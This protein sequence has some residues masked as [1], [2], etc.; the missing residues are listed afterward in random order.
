MSI[1]ILRLKAWCHNVEQNSDLV[2]YEDALM[3]CDIRKLIAVAEA[4]KVY[5][6]SRKVVEKELDWG[7]FDTLESALDNLEQE[8]T[9]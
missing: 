4:A 1:T 9:T 3:V 6:V 7:L 5:L 2:E 8:P